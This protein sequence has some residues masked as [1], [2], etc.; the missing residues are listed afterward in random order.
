MYMREVD[1]SARLDTDELEM[2]RRQA[3]DSIFCNNSV[4]FFLLL[5]MNEEDDVLVRT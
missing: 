5:S 4:D 3:V 2:K 1:A